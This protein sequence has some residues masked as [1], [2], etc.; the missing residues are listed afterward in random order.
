MDSN[1]IKGGDNKTGIDIHTKNSIICKPVYNM[2]E[3]MERTCFQLEFP[4]ADPLGQWSTTM[5]TP[6]SRCTHR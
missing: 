6:V 5:C 4:V 1:K 2:E 3:G